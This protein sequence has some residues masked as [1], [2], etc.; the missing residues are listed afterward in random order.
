MNE[1]IYVR[2]SNCHPT[3]VQFYYNCGIILNVRANVLVTSYYP[4]PKQTINLWFE[5]F[6]PPPSSH[7]PKKKKLEEEIVGRPDQAID[8]LSSAYLLVLYMLHPNCVSPNLNNHIWGACS[9]KPIWVVAELLGPMRL[10]V[11]ITIVNHI[12]LLGWRLHNWTI[13]AVSVHELWSRLLNL[14]DWYW[15]IYLTGLGHYFHSI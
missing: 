8:I 5:Y 4:V 3:L 10:F 6:Q 15:L 11:W 14:S 9:M 7:P 1:W 13:H 2:E 12:I